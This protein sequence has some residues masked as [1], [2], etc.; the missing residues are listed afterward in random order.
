MDTLLE[1]VPSSALRPAY[2]GDRHYG[3]CDEA[4]CRANKVSVL[5]THCGA[6]ACGC[7]DGYVGA[8]T[9]HFAGSECTVECAHGRWDGF[10]GCAC[11]R[12]WFGFACKR[13]SDDDPLE[14]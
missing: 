6:R 13:M 10:T 5:N 8:R 12:G 9:S 1:L 4:C 11:E 2:S 14:P 7:K 3:C